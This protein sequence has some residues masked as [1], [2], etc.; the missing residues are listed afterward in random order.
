M[1]KGTVLVIEDDKMIQNLMSTTLEISNYAYQIAPNAEQGILK[2]A[3][4]NP[5]VIILDLGLPD[6]DGI[7][8]IKKVRSFSNIPIIVVSA[9]IDNEDKISA[10]DAGADDYLTKP[11]NTEE[12]LARIRVALRRKT[13]TSEETVQTSVFTN[14]NLK[15]DYAQGCVYV[16]DKEV[17]LTAIE[18]KLLCLLA[19]NLG[20]VLTHNYIKKE[21]WLDD[22]GCDSQ[23][24]LRVFVTNLRKKLNASD[25]IKTHIGIGYRMLQQGKN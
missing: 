5:D 10:L 21:I 3:S 14:G 17:H 24:S 2:A 11:F 18:Y 4:Y 23:L 9:R 25:Y 6:M 1:N 13:Y 22:N 20:K 12:L 7:E 16:D 8:V 19:K 15:I